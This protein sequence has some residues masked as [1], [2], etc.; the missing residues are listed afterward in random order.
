MSTTPRLV[1]F[2]SDVASLR[3]EEVRKLIAAS[4]ERVNN[5]EE[6]SD[7]DRVAFARHNPFMVHWR[8]TFDRQRKQGAPDWAMATF[9]KACEAAY[10]V[11]P[12]E[13]VRARYGVTWVLPEKDIPRL[14]EQD[15][16]FWTIDTRYGL[17]HPVEGQPRVTAFQE[18][19]STS[20][21][22]PFL[23]YKGYLEEPSADEEEPITVKHELILAVPPSST[24]TV[25]RT[26]KS[27]STAPPTAE[28]ST[29]STF[30][31]PKPVVEVSPLQKVRSEVRPK[32]K[33]AGGDDKTP[34]KVQKTK[35]TSS[36]PSTARTTV[37][38][39]ILKKTTPRETVPVVSDIPARRVT[40][41]RA[42]SVASTV[43][44][45]DDKLPDLSDPSIPPESD[46]ASSAASAPTRKSTRRKTPTRTSRPQSSKV[47]RKGKGKA[48]AVESEAEQTEAES[49]DDDSQYTF[50]LPN[51]DTISK[52]F[53]K[54]R[55]VEEFPLDKY[56]YKSESAYGKKKK[57]IITFTPEA[58]K[59]AIRVPLGTR[60]PVSVNLAN[61]L[62]ANVSS[63]FAFDKC[64]HCNERF[65]HSCNPQG[66]V[67]AG[68]KI[69]M[70][71]CN[72]CQRVGQSC[73]ATYPI[74]KLMLTKDLL[75]TFSLNSTHELS[76]RL[77]HVLELQNLRS[78]LREQANALTA[79]IRSLDDQISFGQAQ[80]RESSADPTILVS[81]L[82][83]GEEGSLQLDD[84]TLHLL[85]VAA[86]WEANNLD[87]PSRLQLNEETGEYECVPLSSGLPSREPSPFA[88]DSMDIDEEPPIAGPSRSR[89]TTQEFVLNPG[90]LTSSSGPSGVSSRFARKAASTSPTVS[91]SARDKGKEVARSLS[92]AATPR[93]PSVSFKDPSSSEPDV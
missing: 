12:T 32:R 89:D 10:Q 87:I 90:L 86:G 77:S 51:E 21:P 46:A 47:D 17:G 39:P 25:R 55:P 66:P 8:F 41:S 72:C 35:K 82:A 13:A 24:Q 3:V 11:F 67:A 83:Q 18:P 44:P 53:A 52:M 54:F 49:E 78:K 50:E 43:A 58:S 14:M 57:A 70:R 2:W 92:A 84:H 9:V 91:R 4:F 93:K 88:N 34:A 74:S 15:Y 19:G 22:Q 71:K 16:G 28:S 75:N 30:L 33:Q 63:S 56:G 60:V 27:K 81:Q 73:T 85:S 45:T 36:A 62:K 64:V 65:D 37:P 31:P 69:T 80:L 79:T 61:F 38:R 23:P 7:D 68:S 5:L 6:A 20:H 40:R 42:S 59:F 48:A 29:P 76:Q 1:N 26:T